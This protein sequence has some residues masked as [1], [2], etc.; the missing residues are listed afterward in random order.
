MKTTFMKKRMSEIVHDPALSERRAAAAVRRAITITGS[1]PT[2]LAETDHRGANSSSVSGP[3]GSQAALVGA[4]TISSE[5]AQAAV[6][7]IVPVPRCRRRPCP[8]ELVGVERVRSRRDVEAVF[9]GHVR[10]T[11]VAASAWVRT[12]LSSHCRWSISRL[13]GI[14]THR[15]RRVSVRTPV[16]VPQSKQQTSNARQ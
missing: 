14:Q 4:W 2:S 12:T 7:V 13:I 1:S 6:A 3:I 11:T 9:S 5:M 16:Q 15:P 10:V 8:P